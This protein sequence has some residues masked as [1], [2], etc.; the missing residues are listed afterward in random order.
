[1]KYAVTLLLTAALLPGAETPAD[2]I[3]DAIRRNDLPKVKTVI[4]D[5]GTGVRDR[6]GNTPLMLAAGFGTV[7]AMRILL[8]AKADVNA[9]NNTGTTALIWGAHDLGKMTLLVSKGANINAVTKQG[10]TALMVAAMSGNALPLVKY[11]LDHGADP[12]PP[13]PP[14]EAA[15]DRARRPPN[16]ALLEAI[17]SNE[18]EAALLLL[19]KTNPGVIRS[20][21][22]GIAL[23]FAAGNGNHAVVK[24]LLAA[25]VD[26]N[27]S[28]PPVLG[29]GVKNGNIEI[30]ALT[31]LISAAA[32]ADPS[33][34]D[35]LLSAGANPNARDVRGMTPLMLALASD[36]PNVKTVQLLLAK[37]A[38]PALKD[39]YGDDAR[40][41]AVRYQNKPIMDA[42][43]LE[44]RKPAKIAP[45]AGSTRN[46][47]SAAEQGIAILQRT[48]TSFFREGGCPAC[49]ALNMTGMAAAIA[50]KAGIAINEAVHRTDSTTTLNAMRQFD[51]LLPQGLQA[52]GHPDL[53]QYAMVHMKAGGIEPN[54]TT[55]TILLNELRQQ[56]ADGSWS[57]FGGAIARAPVEDGDFHRTAMG[58][59]VLTE[60][61]IPALRDEIRERVSRAAKWLAAQEP[62]ATDDR[63]MQILGLVWADAG[64][65]V[66]KRVK[67]LV[68]LQKSD[69]GWA[70]TKWFE[71]DAYATGQSLVALHAGGMLAKDPVYR[72]GV[73]YLLSTQNRDGSWHVRSR[74]PKFQPY[75]ESGFPY[76]G[77]QWISSMATGWAVMAL[78]HAVPPAARAD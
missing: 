43:K 26:V 20:P 70:Q 49:H 73:Q 66:P 68:A 47:R 31:A 15:E 76:G 29:P 52:P 30:G 12:N 37:G 17:V 6:R 7:E 24:D 48:T 36:R 74:S 32:Y 59:R 50:A 61:G 3:Y 64:A 67:E 62:I 13:P 11:L 39:K 42:L 69:G 63:N 9:A 8:D 16:L 22:G 75:F 34:I 10:R 5:S 51:V 58:I 2:A 41:W 4:A 72:R 23:T 38:D 28:S 53:E 54:I 56:S 55:D 46:V 60:Y 40:V 78:A 77:D 14:A 57:G 1:M 33:V 45:V 44:T 71:S 35:L 27:F 25:G 19:A 18:T 21:V 65:T